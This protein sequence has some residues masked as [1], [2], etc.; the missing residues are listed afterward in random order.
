MGIGRMLGGVVDDVSVMECRRGAN[1]VGEKKIIVAMAEFQ[2]TRGAS[3][4]LN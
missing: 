3:H 4:H 2:S 1:S